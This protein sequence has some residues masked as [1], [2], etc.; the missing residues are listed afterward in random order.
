MVSIC[1]GLTKFFHYTPNTFIKDNQITKVYY[2]FWGGDWGYISPYKT[3]DKLF[4]FCRYGLFCFVFFSFCLSTYL[5]ASLITV[6]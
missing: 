1:K 4:S 3:L 5:T 6:N 2:H